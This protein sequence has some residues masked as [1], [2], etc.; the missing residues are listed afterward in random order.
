MDRPLEFRFHREAFDNPRIPRPVAVD[1]V[2]RVGD[3]VLL[4]GSYD[5]YKS[6][7]ALELAWSLSTGNPWLGYYPIVQPSRVGLIQAEI[8]EGAYDERLR[9]FPIAAELFY[10]SH[11]GF[12]FD[13]LDEVRELIPDLSL[14]VVM[15]DPI[16]IMWPSHAANGE[17]FS[18]NVKNHVSPLMRELKKLRTGIVLI[19]HDP[20]P[21][22]ENRGRASG[23]AALLND[24]DVR[25]FIDKNKDDSI[26]VTVR[27]RLQR[28]ARPFRAVFNEES[29]RLNWA[30]ATRPVRTTNQ[31]RAHLTEYEG[32]SGRAANRLTV[33]RSQSSASGGTTQPKAP[34]PD[35][36][37]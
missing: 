3:L 16:G 10:E 8:E 11:I 35:G 15:F 18:E 37:E 17:P 12:T 25:I 33:V 26:Q 28:A 9:Q 5:T 21:S 30:P 27:N 19:H 24:P 1:G 4:T 22:G 31:P 14:D 6:S 13:R 20:K 34:L 36:T 7:L 32:V 29:R 2:M 23:S